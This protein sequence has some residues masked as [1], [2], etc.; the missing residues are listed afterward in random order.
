MSENDYYLKYLKY[1]SKYLDLQNILSAGGPSEEDITKDLVVS[2]SSS[3]N[4]I[5]KIIYDRKKKTIPTITI[6]DDTVLKKFNYILTNHQMFC[7]LTDLLTDDRKEYLNAIRIGTVGT[8]EK[9]KW[10]PPTFRSTNPQTIKI[11]AKDFEFY[12]FMVAVFSE[13]EG[14]PGPDIKEVS[15]EYKN[16]LCKKD[17]T[18]FSK[19]TRLKEKYN[20]I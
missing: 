20:K 4:F 16:I 7:N 5:L 18:A 9:G 2:D 12:L 1:K 13:R 11:A 15:S 3:D 19:F 6:T 17:A 14:Y 8:T 10:I